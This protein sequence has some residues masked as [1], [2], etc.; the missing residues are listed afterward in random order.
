MASANTAGDTPTRSHN[1]DGGQW[2]RGW[3][4]SSTPPPPLPARLQ[5]PTPGISHLS[6]NPWGCLCSTSRDRAGSTAPL[7]LGV[8]GCLREPSGSAKEAPSPPRE[9]PAAPRDREK[10]AW[11]QGPAPGTH[12]SPTA[13][14][15]GSA[16]GA[17]PGGQQWNPSCRSKLVFFQGLYWQAHS[18]VL[19]QPLVRHPLALSHR[20]PSFLMCH[21]SHRR[22]RSRDGCRE[23]RQG[24][25]PQSREVAQARMG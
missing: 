23:H 4:P 15:V 22:G 12:V 24:L 20:V 2:G 13:G 21:G 5:H 10:Q 1:R 17:E 14:P 16:K 25:S 8:W 19:I 6:R 3:M 11:G 18:W 9:A 7:A